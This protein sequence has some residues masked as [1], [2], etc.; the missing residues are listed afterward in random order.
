MMLIFDVMQHRI[1]DNDSITPGTIY[2]PRGY[3]ICGRIYEAC[4]LQNILPATQLSNCEPS[5]TTQTGNGKSSSIACT[6]FRMRSYGL[7]S[8]FTNGFYSCLQLLVSRHDRLMVRPVLRGSQYGDKTTETTPT[9]LKCDEYIYIYIYTNASQ[10]HCTISSLALRHS[11]ISGALSGYCTWKSPQTT[12][13]VIKF[14]SGHLELT[15][16]YPL[17]EFRS[18]KRG[19][20]SV[21]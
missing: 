9:Q 20:R 3:T 4:N 21:N 11:A 16:R 8:K 18:N 12:H 19:H 2:S 7:R 13:H 5:R 6:C 10:L 15:W 14:H 17:S 1:I